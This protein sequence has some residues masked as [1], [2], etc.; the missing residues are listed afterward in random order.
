MSEM[1]TPQAEPIDIESIRASLMRL[2]G[3]A[4]ANVQEP[5]EG[6]LARVLKANSELLSELARHK[7]ALELCKMQRDSFCK[8]PNDYYEDY[9]HIETMNEA[10][11][12][13]LNRKEIR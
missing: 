2:D 12:A 3:A 4:V 10:L 13:I 9:E 1:K 8:M 11:T 5:S 6:D 7:E